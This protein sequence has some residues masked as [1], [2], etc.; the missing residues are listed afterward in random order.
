MAFLGP[1]SVWAAAASECASEQNSFWE[2]HDVLFTHT[3]G[4][5]KGVFTKPALKQYAADL[6]L[7]RGAFNNCVDSGRYEDYVRGQT[8]Q[9]QL[10]GVT[11]TPTLMVNGQKLSPVPGSFE[12]LRS[13]ILTLAR[14]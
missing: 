6:G 11:S 4:R 5:D 10:Q 12:D 8:Q 7:D 3:A 1:E 2:Y 9:G 13:A 14:R